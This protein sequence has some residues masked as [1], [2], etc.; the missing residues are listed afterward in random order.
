MEGLG[1]RLSYLRKKHDLSEKELAEKLKVND[2]STVK[3][4]ERGYCRPTIKRLRE[5]SK[6]Y[7]ID[8][9]RIIPNRKLKTNKL[10]SI[11]KDAEGGHGILYL[12]NVKSQP[13][14]PESIIKNVR[15]LEIKSGIM[16]IQVGNETLTHHII[17]VDDILGFLEEMN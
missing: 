7:R 1:E 9:E 13:F 10:N 6:I 15:I 17:A 11:L 2:Q 16:K 12:K 8:L 5:I 14:F 3:D 4:W